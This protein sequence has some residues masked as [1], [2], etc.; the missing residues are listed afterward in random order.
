MKM[1]MASHLVA[2]VVKF[3]YLN[4]D[5]CVQGWLTGTLLH[6]SVLVGLVFI[7][8]FVANCTTLSRQNFDGFDEKSR[9][10]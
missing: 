7:C 5:L 6:T 2:V 1:L 8:S 10:C 9:K 3:V 4:S